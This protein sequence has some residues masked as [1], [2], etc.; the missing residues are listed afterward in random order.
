MHH[1]MSV[2]AGTSK[3]RFKT[4]SKFQSRDGRDQFDVEARY[5]V[6]IGQMRPRGVFAPSP[7]VLI[8]DC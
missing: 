4:A 2:S 5:L 3:K 6:I 7:V 1:D 8:Y